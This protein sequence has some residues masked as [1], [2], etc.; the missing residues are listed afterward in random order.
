MEPNKHDHRLGQFADLVVRVGVNVQPGQGVVLHADTGHLDI[1]RA[2]V[3]RAYTAGAAWVDVVWTDG[4]MRRAHLDHAPTQTLSASRGWALHRIKTWADQRIASIALVGDPHPH[5]LDGVDPT[6]A[7]TLALDETTALQ[8]AILGRQLRWTIAAAPNTGWATH[9]YGKPDLDRLW[10]AVATAMRLDHPDPITQWRHRAATLAAR[11]AA[12]NA[13]QLT[14]LRYTGDGTDLRVGLIPGCHW[15]GGA[16]TD[17]D[18]IAYLPNI[19]TEEVFTSP[20]RHHADGVVR[21]TRPLIV[22]GHLI[23]G[24]RITLTHGQITQ[25]CATTGADA[26]RAH[27]DTDPGARHLGEVALVDRDSPTAT[28]DT[29]FHNTLLD[30]NT[31]CHIAWGQSFPFTVT[32]GLAMTPAQRAE[33]GLNTSTVHTDIVIGGE[34]ITVTGTGPHGTIPIIHHDDWVLP[35]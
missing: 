21:V 25:V 24:L 9:L 33:T 16:T 27:L 22:A 18:G 17:P 32:G 13:Q 14:E 2:V 34:G 12:L 4:P 5:L 10:D 8:D 11:A 1:A 28:A 19:P 30:E 20:H 6:R 31:A 29:V 3:A 23:T 26:V 15:T 7:A 35:D